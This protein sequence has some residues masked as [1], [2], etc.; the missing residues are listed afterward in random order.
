MQKTTGAKL[1]MVAHLR[2]CVECLYLI[3]R[4][5]ASSLLSKTLKYSANTSGVNSAISRKDQGAHLHLS[6]WT[7]SDLYSSNILRIY[8]LVQV[9]HLQVLSPSVGLALLQAFHASIATVPLTKMT[10]DPALLFTAMTITVFDVA[11]LILFFIQ[12]IKG[13]LHINVAKRQNL[14]SHIWAWHS[15]S[16]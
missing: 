1:E 9:R 14:R 10:S 3:S 6:G 12:K 13:R 15:N 11:S 2:T 5:N 8:C 4:N 7:K 16:C